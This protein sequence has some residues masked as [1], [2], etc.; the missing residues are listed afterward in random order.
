M[1]LVRGH[2]AAVQ[3]L[4][5]GIHALPDVASSFA[6]AQ[7]AWRFFGNPRVTLAVLAAPLVELARQDSG[8]QCE[9]YALV[10]HDWSQL[11]YPLHTGKTDRVTLSSRATPDGYEILTALL[12]SDRDG[13]PIAPLEISLR[14]AD[15]VHESRSEQ[16]RPPLSPLD[17][18][19]PLMEHVAQLALPRRSVHLI[20]AEA[21]SVDHYRQWQAAGHL[22]LVR[23]DD[24]IVQQNGRDTRCSVIQAEQQSLGQFQDTRDVLYHGRPARQWIAETAVTLTRAAQRNRPGVNDRRTIPGPPLPLRLVIS[25]V[26]SLDGELL[27]TWLLLTNVPESVPAATIALWYYWRWSIEKFF[28]LLKSAGQ[29]LEEWQQESAGAIA[30][31]LWVACMA[32]ATVWRLARSEHPQAE[33]TRRV[34]VR[35]SGRQMKRGMSYTTPALLAGLWNLLA[36]IDLL[37]QHSPQELREFASLVQPSIKPP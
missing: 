11:M 9:H 24:R 6:A 14:A 26:R 29:Q 30:R 3:G 4:A 15:G 16:V 18:L 17:E 19:A 5:G 35:L 37:Q 28:K 25:E 36:M 1:T 32:C 34:L 20:D 2:G 22:F 33:T 27:A 23:A 10:V 31:R 8:T 7:A 12:I 13:Q 21:D